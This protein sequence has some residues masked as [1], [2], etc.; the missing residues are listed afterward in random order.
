LNGEIDPN[1]IVAIMGKTEGNGLVNDFSRGYAS[2]SCKTL[3]SK[4]T[5][6]SAAEVEERVS[7]VMSGGTEG[8][9]SP[10]LTV[11]TRKFVESDSTNKEKRLTIGISRTRDFKPEELGTMIQVEEVA[12]KVGEA[13][14][15]ALIDNPS[16][17]HFVQIKCPLLTSSK[18]KEANNKG[19][20][21]V[22]SDTLKSMGYSRAASALGVALALGEV[23]KEKI[24][25]DAIYVDR[26]VF[27]NVASTSAGVELDCCEIIV[28]GNSINS[29]S[30][31]RIGHSTMRDGIDGDGVRDALK[32]A[33]L[34]FEWQPSDEQLEKI[35]N[36]FAKCGAPPSGEIRGR[37]HTMLSDSM[38]S[39]TR[40]ARSVVG[41]VIASIIKDTMIY[42]SGGSEHQ[43][44]PGGGPIAAVI[45]ID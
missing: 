3:I 17:V 29:V 2:L 10:H 28:M 21:V 43:G 32:N 38:I 27:S 18:I 39:S 30:E 19:K 22:T 25:G 5:G 23:D 31:M 24:N 44:P 13:V 42:V 8:V 40:H 34:D 12:K 15:D 14:K 11:F 45:K 36:M 20:K 16:D 1:E 26:S 4:H 7:L 33:G 37:R 35:V 9:L 41:A 6:K